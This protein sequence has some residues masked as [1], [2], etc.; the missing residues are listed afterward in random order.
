MDNKIEVTGIKHCIISKE[1]KLP[2][3]GKFTFFM[4]YGQG[5]HFVI[6]VSD[7]L[8]EF[9][10][11]LNSMGQHCEVWIMEAVLKYDFVQLSNFGNF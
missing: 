11:P 3:H 2:Q 4:G 9:N 7:H 1:P 10:M 5:Q 8:L 6:F